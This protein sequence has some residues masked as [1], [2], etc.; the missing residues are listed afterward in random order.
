MQTSLTK[1]GNKIFLSFVAFF[2]TL[3]ATAQDTVVSTTTTS[4][5]ASNTTSSNTEQ[6]WYTQPWVLIVG[7]LVVLLIIILAMRGSNTSK[8]SVTVTK[9]VSRD[10][11]V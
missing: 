11:D 6:M 4:T 3:I 8:D 1:F 5:N 2:A 7:G 10:T 9:T